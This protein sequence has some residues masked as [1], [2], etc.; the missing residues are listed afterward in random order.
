[1]ETKI[2][3]DEESRRVL[4]LFRL[5]IVLLATLD[6]SLMLIRELPFKPDVTGTSVSLCISLM[7]FI[8]SSLLNDL[9]V[10]TLC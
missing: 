6:M 7:N 9:T 10:L 4:D 5:L 1:M 3:G 8:A 2:Y